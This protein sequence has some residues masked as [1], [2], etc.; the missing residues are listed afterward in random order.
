MLPGV[1]E[2]K[3]P[4]SKSYSML[5]ISPEP[6]DDYGGE[7]YYAWLS[8]TGVYHGSLYTAPATS[9][10][11]TRVF[12]G[13]KLLAKSAL[14]NAKGEIT[15]IALTHWHILILCGSTV[16]A[17]SRLDDSVVFQE[18]VSD[19]GSKIL[20]I[21]MDPKNSTYWVST[22]ESIYEIL[23][24]KEDR[25]VWRLKM[26]DKSFDEAYR[27]AEVRSTINS[28][29]CRIILIFVSRLPIRKIP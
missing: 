3:E 1:Q 21:C 4:L 15:S 12:A 2:F 29:S 17:V 24:T 18:D 19:D 9:D 26:A 27:Y 5:S 11:G 16:Y 10:L 7:R 28:S 8:S 22:S 20:G 6:K 14:P 13:S 25:D 23:E